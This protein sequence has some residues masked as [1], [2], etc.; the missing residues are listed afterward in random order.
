[1]EMEGRMREI[2]FFLFLM[3]LE[4]EHGQPEQIGEEIQGHS[5]AA[6][7]GARRG[8]SVHWF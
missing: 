3:D 1:M 8:G 2:Y 4:Q 5:A 7:F 6:Q